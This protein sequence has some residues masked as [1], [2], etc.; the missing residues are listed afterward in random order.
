MYIFICIGTTD[1]IGDSLGPM[2]G[3]LLKQKYKDH[4]NIKVYGDLKSPVDYYNIDNVIRNIDIIYKN[5]ATKI[6]VD[7]ALGNKIGSFIVRCKEN[8]YP[9]KGFNKQKKINGDV[10]IVGVVGK[11]HNN[12]LKNYIELK[13]IH[14][15][16]VKHMAEEIVKS[17]NV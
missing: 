14:E 16:Y 1:I 9:G 17:I 10:C 7:S 15:V 4:E 11:N 5:K 3:S 2:V 13:N 12:C 8:L 6:I